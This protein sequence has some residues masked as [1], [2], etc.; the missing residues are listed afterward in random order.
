MVLA[1]GHHVD[2]GPRA[3]YRAT[4]TSGFGTICVYICATVIVTAMM[5]TLINTPLSASVRKDR[6]LVVTSA[7]TSIRRSPRMVENVPANESEPLFVASQSDAKLYTTLPTI[8]EHI[9]ASTSMP[10]GIKYS[11]QRT[12]I[13]TLVYA[14]HRTRTLRS[15]SEHSSAVLRRDRLQPLTGCLLTTKHLEHCNNVTMWNGQYQRVCYVREMCI[16]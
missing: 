3:A 6:T 15:A 10:P 7:L 14:Q 11:L 2:I 16:F 12:D 5:L 1:E 13:H 8:L 4:T 9:I